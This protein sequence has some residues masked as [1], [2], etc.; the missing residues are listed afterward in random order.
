MVTTDS[1]Y[2]VEI[3]FEVLYELLEREFLEDDID[4]GLKLD[5]VRDEGEIK[6]KGIV[7]SCGLKRH[8]GMKHKNAKALSEKPSK[9]TASEFSNLVKR[10]SSICQ[11][12]LCLSEFMFISE[13]NLVPLIL[14]MMMH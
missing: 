4:F 14:L 1:D 13:T 12:N 8:E 10:C 9:L 3:N 5:S 6:D 11:Q 2:L 7:S